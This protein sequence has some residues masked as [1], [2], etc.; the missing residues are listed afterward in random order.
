MDEALPCS[1]TKF[2]TEQW[3]KLSPIQTHTWGLNQ[4]ALLSLAPVPSAAPRGP[5]PGLHVF[6]MRVYSMASCYSLLAVPILLFFA[7]RFTQDHSPLFFVPSLPVCRLSPCLALPGRGARWR[8]GQEFFPFACWS[9][10]C[11]PSH[12]SLPW[13]QLLPVTTGSNFQYYSPSL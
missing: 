3:L 11:H 7:P 12:A 13:Q 4:M 8:T 2:F 1:L 9:C 6:P 10:Q 5:I